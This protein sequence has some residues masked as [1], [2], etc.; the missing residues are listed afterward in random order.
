MRSLAHYTWN[1][2]INVHCRGLAVIGTFGSVLLDCKNHRKMTLM[3]TKRL[4]SLQS[5]R[6]LCAATSAQALAF[7]VTLNRYPYKLV[8]LRQHRNTSTS[9][10]SITG[11]TTPAL[12]TVQ[13]ANDL[14][15][16]KKVPDLF[17]LQD[18]VVVITRGARG[19]GLAL[20]FAVAEVGG[21]I[22]IGDATAEPHEHYQNLKEVVSRVEYYRLAFLFWNIT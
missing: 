22:A 18:H 9:N 13:R 6:S 16:S 11:L 17:S 8:G 21:K 14:Y 7:S 2:R 15:L 10:S 4:L 5:C 12:S 3:P 1:K 20:V 19:I